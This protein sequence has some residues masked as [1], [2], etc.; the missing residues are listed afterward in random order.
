[1]PTIDENSDVIWG[2]A[3]IGKVI[4]RSERVAF[5]LLEQGLLP[6][7]KLG[8]RWVASRKALLAAVIGEEQA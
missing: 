7:R 5:Y 2:A 1:V 3:N 4:G 8:G 6:G